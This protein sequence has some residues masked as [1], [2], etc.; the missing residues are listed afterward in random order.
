ML[1][2]LARDEC[3]ETVRYRRSFPEQ[4][5]VPEIPLGVFQC[6]LMFLLATAHCPL[7]TKI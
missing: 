7:K 4:S 1:T 5:V 2:H 6:K 3:A